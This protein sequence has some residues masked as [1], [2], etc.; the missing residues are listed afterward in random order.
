V[1]LFTSAVFGQ[2]TNPWPATGSVGI[3]TTSPQYP[4]DV[5]GQVSSSGYVL[6]NRDPHAGFDLS[7]TGLFS[8]NAFDMIAVHR[9]WDPAGLYIAG[10]NASNASVSGWTALTTQHVYIGTPTFNNPN[11]MY[12]NLMNG[13]VGIG[14]TNTNDASNRLFVETGIRTR[15]VTVDQASWPDYVFLPGYRLSPLDSLA[16]YIAS[17]HRLPG[18]PSAD[19]VAT[20]GI[21]LGA[22]EAA[23][24]K[25]VEELTLYV[26]ELN[27]KNEQLQKEVTTLKA[28]VGRRRSR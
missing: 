24:L 21:E 22:G 16:G 7:I 20:N 9:G 17:N 4:L 1:S 3:G 28:V 13:A 19:S 23:L 14:T 26:I 11:Y 8:S 25:K 18:I 15:K 27:K 12:V 10:Y 5:L 6:S 2:N